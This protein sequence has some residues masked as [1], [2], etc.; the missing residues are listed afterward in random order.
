MERLFLGAHVRSSRELGLPPDAALSADEVVR[1]EAT[2]DGWSKAVAGD[3]DLARDPRMMVPV[4]VDARRGLRVLAVLGWTP[5]SLVFSFRKTPGVKL[6]DATTGADCTATHDVA[7]EFPGQST[8]PWWKSLKRPS[9]TSS[10]PSARLED[11]R[12]HRRGADEVTGAIR[13]ADS[14][15]ASR[16]LTRITDTSCWQSQ[17]TRE[18]TSAQALGGPSKM[19]EVSDTLE[20]RPDP[21]RVGRA[22]P[23]REAG[24]G[25]SANKGVRHCLLAASSQQPRP[26]DG[27]HRPG[28]Q[29]RI[30][31]AASP[32]RDHV[33][34]PERRFTDLKT[35]AGA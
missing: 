20:L 10:A 28:A 9:A 4:A 6:V 15:A 35:S 26:L 14:G 3:P 24:G 8:S 34:L 18:A 7:C 13:S 11:A 17:S 31:P 12:R 5:R 19:T 27:Q 16:P 25:A 1:A 32:S 21:C 30:R 33:K 23:A 22:R 2:F 29:T